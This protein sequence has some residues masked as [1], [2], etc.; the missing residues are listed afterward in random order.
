MLPIFYP[1]IFM[2][3]LFPLL[4]RRRVKGPNW[5][6]ESEIARLRGIMA[7]VPTK[8][9]ESFQ[10]H[11]RTGN[12]IRAIREIRAVVPKLSIPDASLITMIFEYDQKQCSN[13]WPA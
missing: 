11:V 4:L 5:L 7:S 10:W 8:A 2:C 12:R 6:K 9:M 1:L 3:I 13:T